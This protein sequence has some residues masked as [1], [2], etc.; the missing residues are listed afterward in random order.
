[1]FA[2]NFDPIER[3]Y[4][5]S[6]AQPSG[7]ITGVIVRPLDLARKQIDLLRQVFPERN[8]LAVLYDTQSADQFTAADQGAKSLNLQVQ[9]FKVDPAYDFAGV[10]EAAAKG[11]AQLVMVQSGPAFTK[12]K[13]ELAELAIKHRLPTMFTFR[14]YVDDGGL[15]RGISAIVASNRGLRDANS[16]RRKTGRIANRAAHK[17][18]ISS[19]SQN[20]QSTWRHYTQWHSFGG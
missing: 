9:A 14:H 7:N 11:G 10:F 13:K 8:R 2:V 6:L 19:Q 16:E 15:M 18:R 5:T 3:G 20:G 12:H 4:V 1:M 17:I